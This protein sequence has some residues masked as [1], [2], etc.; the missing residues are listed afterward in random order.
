MGIALP[1]WRFVLYYSMELFLN[2]KVKKSEKLV[3]FGP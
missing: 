3:K 1:G 2:K